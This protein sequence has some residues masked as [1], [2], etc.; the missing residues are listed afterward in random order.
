MTDAAPCV[1][2]WLPTQFDYAIAV[3]G[4]WGLCPKDPSRL[5][6]RFALPARHRQPPAPGRAVSI[7]PQQRASDS[8][9]LGI[10]RSNGGPGHRAL[11][12]AAAQLPATAAPACAAAAAPP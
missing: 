4:T 5:L 7:P 1:Q 9:G 11:S 10:P 6:L 12:G 2:W 8:V 3:N